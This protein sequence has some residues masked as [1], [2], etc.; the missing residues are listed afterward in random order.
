MNSLDHRAV[1][2][3]RH[4]PEEG[5]AQLEKRGAIREVS[6]FE[7]GQIVA[8]LQRQFRAEGHDTI[9]VAG[10]HAEI[11]QLTDA[12]R[13]DRKERGEFGVGYSFDRTSPSNGLRP[14]TRNCPTTNRV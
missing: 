1:E 4:S 3:M 9:L 12:I 7:R 13:Q 2:T 8:E 14:R 5:F 10:T 11:S 6:I